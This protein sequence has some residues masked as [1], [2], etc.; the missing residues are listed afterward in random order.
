MA[1]RLNTHPRR[2]WERVRYRYPRALYKK[3][4]YS[5]TLYQHRMIF[6][7]TRREFCRSISLDLL[8]ATEM[9]R[10]IVRYAKRSK[11]DKFQNTHKYTRWIRSSGREQKMHG[12]VFSPERESGFECRP[13]YYLTP[14][15]TDEMSITSHKRR[16]TTSCQSLYEGLKALE[17][18]V[19]KRAFNNEKWGWMYLVTRARYT[20]DDSRRM[21]REKCTDVFLR[22]CTPHRFIVLR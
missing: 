18:R 3:K 22:G 11:A 16:I 7:E 4:C 21:C 9:C 14:L 15:E 12:H 8:L 13:R 19:C 10:S 17:S 5:C 1:G 6:N 20:G 2:R